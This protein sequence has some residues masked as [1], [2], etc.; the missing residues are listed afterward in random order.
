MSDEAL[1]DK[2]IVDL[3]EEHELHGFAQFPKLCSTCYSHK[4]YNDMVQDR[5][6]ISRATGE[7]E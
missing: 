7:F 4:K 2:E 5:S 1:K 3:W 6:L